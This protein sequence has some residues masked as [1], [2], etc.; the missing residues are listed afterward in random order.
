MLRNVIDNKQHFKM[1]KAG[2]RWLVSGITVIG[3]G[4][5]LISAPL[6]INA[7]P[8]ETQVE[9]P[10]QTNATTSDQTVSSQSASS[11]SQAASSTQN[12]QAQKTATNDPTVTTQAAATHP[13]TNQSSVQT[14]AN[15]S[16]PQKVNQ[17]GNVGNVD[18]TPTANS[19][20]ALRPNSN[21]AAQTQ[22]NA[23]AAPQ[24][25]SQSENGGAANTTPAANPPAATKPTTQNI[26]PETT[27]TRTP[28]TGD[29]VK[30]VNV[31]KKVD[32]VDKTEN[33]TINPKKHTDEIDTN[34][35]P[36]TKIKQSPIFVDGQ[37]ANPPGKDAVSK[38]HKIGNE[39]GPINR[40]DWIEPPHE[41][42]VIRSG[43]YNGTN[44]FMTGWADDN[45]TL[46]L[47][48]FDKNK[49]LT[50]TEKFEG[51]N[52]PTF[53]INWTYT[54]RQRDVKLYWKYGLLQ[55]EVLSSSRI[56]FASGPHYIDNIPVKYVDQHG[57]E[58]S[59]ES[60]VGGYA[61]TF[62]NV[63]V[64]HIEGYRLIQV[65]Y[66]N[67]E[68][69]FLIT[70]QEKTTPTEWT[71]EQQTNVSGIGSRIIDDRNTQEVYLTYKNEKTP[72][73][74]L[75]ATPNAFIGQSFQKGWVLVGMPQPVG[76][77]LIFVYEPISEYK[78]A[79]NYL[80]SGTGKVM[81]V[82]YTAIGAGT[83]E[84]GSPEFYNYLTDTELVKGVLN[85]DATINVYYKLDPSKPITPVNPSKPNTPDK[86][87]IVIPVV[88]KTPETPTNP[89]T[90][91]TPTEPAT[92]QPTTPDVPVTPVVV[93]TAKTPTDDPETLTDLE[94]DLADKSKVQKLNWNTGEW[95]GTGKQLTQTIPN[96]PVTKAL[97]S[98][99]APTILHSNVAKPS[100]KSVAK[101]AIGF[102]ANQKL[103]QTGDYEAQQVT[104]IGSILLAI[105][106]LFA[107]LIVKKKKD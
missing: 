72:V 95:N 57:N 97:N 11:G 30:D 4:I 99:Q 85:K 47:Y 82:P 66:M 81:H 54:D 94:V 16:V 51:P 3:T 28:K 73:F 7:S 64:P 69:K 36:G 55:M 35:F 8:I 59:Q 6:I 13:D 43:F 60:K 56:A 63:E 79:I 71:Y 53:D 9:N 91:V 1:Y 41:N 5:G 31:I 102:T 17:G 98:Q 67:D 92:D 18:A 83:Y 23:S 107:G 100:H 44:T 65:P 93:E 49:Q 62:V 48:T 101:S 68:H 37:L 26:K 50:K 106:A 80:E 42:E 32:P 105:T 84:I 74:T 19:A 24:N 10:Q 104:I 22:R 87:V 58:I 12:N 70:N 27:P 88:P 77:P 86:P 29:Q 15:T 96:A 33:P 75:K 52:S 21:N 25:V 20:A 38:G 34:Y 2:K 76:N 45:K 89:T 90:P 61:N 14:Q 39:D 103:P 46:Y 40:S 78:L